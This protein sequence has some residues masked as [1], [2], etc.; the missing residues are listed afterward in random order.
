MLAA[1]IDPGSGGPGGSASGQSFLWGHS[2]VQACFTYSGGSVLQNHLVLCHAQKPGGRRALPRDL[3][4]D[5]Q[6][7]SGFSLR[8]PQL[9][10]DHRQVT[11]LLAATSS[12]LKTGYQS[13]SSPSPTEYEDDDNTCVKHFL[14][15]RH[16]SNT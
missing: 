12:S 13:M 2:L 10:C 3:E 4:Q 1:A 11:E 16:H 15:A 8:S 6:A 14:C 7:Q 9:L 5:S